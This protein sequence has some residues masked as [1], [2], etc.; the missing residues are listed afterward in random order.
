MTMAARLEQ[1]AEAVAA[2]APDL[3][4]KGQRI[5]VQ[6]YRLLALGKPVSVSDIA[7]AASVTAD[8]VGESLRSWPLVFWDDHDRLVGFWGLAIEPLQPT[9]AIEVEDETLY[10]WCA[11]DTLFIT[12]ILGTETRV[13][14]TDPNDGTDIELIVGPDE[15]IS[16]NPAGTAVSLLLPDGEF[17]ADTIQRFCHRIHFFSSS[18]SAREWI[19][20]RPDMFSI[21]VDEAFE[22]GRVTNRLRLGN[23]HRLNRLTGSS[24][25]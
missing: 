21:T 6:T 13:S 18:E 2:A 17:G 24:S 3:D 20:E 5:A 7:G 10:G 15:V 22:L 14:S 16:T 23:Q 4:P 19:G 8:R 1:W 11:W 9:H 12:E 25:Q